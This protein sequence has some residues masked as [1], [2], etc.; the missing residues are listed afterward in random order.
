MLNT[1]DQ[2]HLNGIQRRLAAAGKTACAK[3]SR[4]FTKAVVIGTP[5][6]KGSLMISFIESLPDDENRSGWFVTDYPEAE[7]KE[8]ADDMLLPSPASYRD[9]HTFLYWNDMVNHVLENVS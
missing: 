1:F 6:V 9:S 2:T 7:P 8:V 5:N 3:R 4:V